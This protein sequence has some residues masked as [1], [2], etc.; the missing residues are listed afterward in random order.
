MLRSLSAIRSCDREKTFRDVSPKR[1]SA[2]VI[3]KHFRLEVWMDS[4]SDKRPSLR[5]NTFTGTSRQLP[6]CRYVTVAFSDN[7]HD[8]SRCRS[9]AGCKNENSCETVSRAKTVLI[10]T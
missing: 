7:T 1:Y 3:A 2:K 4:V 10:P 5:L 9:R 6:L 8:I